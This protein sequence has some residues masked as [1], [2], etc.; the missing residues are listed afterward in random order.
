VNPRVATPLEVIV[1]TVAALTGAVLLMSSVIAIKPG[2]ASST[3]FTLPT[4]TPWN[5]TGASEM[6]P[7]TGSCV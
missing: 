3:L 4:S 6:S 5:S 1:A 7:E 2:F